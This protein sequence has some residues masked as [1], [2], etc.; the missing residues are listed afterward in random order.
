MRQFYFEKLEVWQEAR[1]L[2]REVYKLTQIFPVEERFGLTSQLR[3]AASSIAANIAE[4]MARSTEKDKARFINQAFG[5]AIEVINFLILA[6]DLEF[7]SDQEY[8]QTRERVEKITN[9]LNSLYNK[10]NK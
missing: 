8:I 9:Q 1:A 7:L 10:F 2:V 6:S 4:G 3:R 5:S